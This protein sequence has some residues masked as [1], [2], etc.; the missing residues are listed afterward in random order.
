MRLLITL[1]ITTQSPTLEET[2]KIVPDLGG[3]R[4]L[5]QLCRPIENDF[6]AFGNRINS[7]ASTDSLIQLEEDLRSIAPTTGDV[8]ATQLADIRLYDCPCNGSES[9]FGNSAPRWGFYVVRLRMKA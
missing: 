4:F 7:V 6:I 5:V 2:V 3:F 1:Q 9:L 8:V